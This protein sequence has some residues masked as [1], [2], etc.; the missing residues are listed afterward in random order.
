LIRPSWRW[1]WIFACASVHDVAFM[2][3][4]P[5]DFTRRRRADVHRP[6]R[7]N[8]AARRDDGFEVALLNLLGGDRRPGL[9]REGKVRVHDG[10]NQ[11][12]AEESEQNLLVS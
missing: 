8:R 4:E 11:H 12:H 9:P 1:N 3:V 7:L 5:D 10:A 6:H 2:R